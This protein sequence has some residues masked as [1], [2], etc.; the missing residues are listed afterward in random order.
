[1]EKCEKVEGDTL[2]EVT[3]P[4]GVFR[5]ARLAV[6]SGVHQKRNN[7]LHDELF[8]DGEG[9]P[10]IRH[11]GELKRIPRDFDGARVL[12]LGGGE[13]AGDIV[14]DMMRL[15]TTAKVI[16]SIPNGQHFFRKYGY[17]FKR[18][19]ITGR[20][21]RPEAFDKQTSLLQGL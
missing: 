17:W 12:V 18:H 3:T 15:G 21:L 5:G 19:P 6:C 14:E 8:G 1:V 20:A 10:K 11:I 2:W 7:T 13:S 16:W 9:G 4:R